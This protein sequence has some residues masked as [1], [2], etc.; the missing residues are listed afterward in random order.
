MVIVRH[1]PPEDFLYHLSSIFHHQD[2][3]QRLCNSRVSLFSSIL[4]QV[5]SHLSL[6]VVDFGTQSSIFSQI[7]TSDIGATIRLKLFTLRCS[8]T[9]SICL[10]KP[11]TS[12]FA[13][14]LFSSQPQCSENFVSLRT[15]QSYVHFGITIVEFHLNLTKKC[16]TNL[17]G[18]PLFTSVGR[19]AE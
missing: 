5:H 3:P 13:S 7:S 12:W 8:S 15:W 17:H 11:R 9:S 19:S 16:S 6:Y 10:A 18:L 4:K 1:K 14:I 2:F